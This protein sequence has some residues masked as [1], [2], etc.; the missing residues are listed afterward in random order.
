[1]EDLNRFE[2][3]LK[4]CSFKSLNEEE[5]SFVFQFISSEEEYESLRSAEIELKKFFDAKV[6][7]NPRKETLLRIKQ[8]R[9]EKIIPTQ[10]FWLRPT[11]PAYA[12]ALLMIVVGVAGWWSG[13]KFGSEEVLVEKIVPRIDTIRIAS[14]PDTIIK[15][16]IIYV[17][18]QPITLVVNQ[19]KENETVTA[20]GVNMKDK[21]ELERLLVS[22]SY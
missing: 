9:A 17:P 4:Q 13:A 19:A 21:E 20:K 12:M 16:K 5:R 18:S 3:L 10:S 14:K 8:S 6:D 11:V 15:E 22:G 2:Q 1:M 7:L